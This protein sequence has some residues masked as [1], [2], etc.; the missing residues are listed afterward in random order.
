MKKTA[1]YG[2]AL[3]ALVWLMACGGGG[4]GADSG[5]AA[6]SAT[7]ASMM[8]SARPDAG[9]MDGA[10]DDAAADAPAPEACTME[11]ATRVADCGMCG[12][13]S[14]T[15]TGGVWVGASECLGQGECAAAAVDEQTTATCV[16]QQRLCGTTCAW[17][18]WE[19]V[20]TGGE[21]TPGEVRV[22]PRV[23]CTNQI[24][25]RCADACT[26]EPQ[27]AEGCG[28]C[29]APPTFAPP[30]P[31]PELLCIPTNDVLLNRTTDPSSETFPA[32]VS[33]FWIM[34]YP[35]TLN[36][37][38]QCIRSG[39]CGTFGTRRLTRPWTDIADYPE[40]LRQ[41]RY[42][43]QDEICAWL[44][45]RAPRLA[46]WTLAARGPAPRAPLYPWWNGFSGGR[47]NDHRG[48]DTVGLNADYATCPERFVATADGL[49]WTRSYFGV[50]GMI[51]HYSELV[52]DV[53]EDTLGQ[54]Y[55]RSITPSLHDP[56]GPADGIPGTVVGG[57]TRDEAAIQWRQSDWDSLLSVVVQ[58]RCVFEVVP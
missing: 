58:F 56:V 44:G 38:R 52:E 14:E 21:C 24:V 40:V 9:P 47:S 22:V 53:F 23:G 30:R 11:G 3:L 36:I 49:P 35:I 43:K 31:S 1:H 18:A 37:E 17:G 41:R 19:D 8:D 32:T 45:G 28:P 10:I 48:C 29:G 13:R 54:Y 5:S 2:S 4:S 57:G 46:E 26:W 7:D 51:G 55:D 25:E 15:C 39:S 6:D 42:E 12:S 34:R 50:E 27:Y 16:T 33:Y 20:T